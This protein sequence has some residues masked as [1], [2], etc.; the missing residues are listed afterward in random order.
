M[1]NSPGLYVHVPFCSAICPYCDF[2]VL[3]GTSARGERFLA[4]LLDEMAGQC[5][6]FDAFDTL[7]FGGGTPSFLRPELLARMVEEVRRR[8]WLAED[9]RIYLEVNPE[10]VDASALKEWR[11]LGTHTLSVGV[12]ALDDESLSWLG[13]RHTAKQA[14]RALELAREAGFDCLSFDLIYGL[15]TQSSSDWSKTLRRAVELE[16][17]HLSCYQLTLHDGTLFGRW[18]REGR[19]REASPDTQG[20]LFR[21][22]HRL[23][24]DAGW[25][26]YEVSNFARSAEHQSRHNEKYWAHTPYLG[27]GPSAHSFAADRRWWNVRSFFDWEKRLLEGRSPVAEHESLDLESLFLETLMLRFR[28]REGLNLTELRARF[29]TDLVKGHAELVDQLVEDGLVEL[30]PPWLRPTLNG[31]AVA[32]SLA[33]A[34]DLAPAA[35]GT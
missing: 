31:L 32:D 35:H 12:Q 9:C 27:L 10:D 25:F 26:G 28:T 24:E 7:Y 20:D 33:R 14:Q 2:A 5:D 19:L 4:R 17:D 8:K 1:T 13:R 30:K 23:L 15:E 6:T 3:P 18:K 22:T 34:F 29:G 21:L 16:P 11:L